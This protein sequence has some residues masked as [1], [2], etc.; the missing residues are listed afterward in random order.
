MVVIPYI[1]SESIA[2]NSII[3]CVGSGQ[4][5]RRSYSKV[6]STNPVIR[7]FHQKLGKTPDFLIHTPGD[8]RGNHTVIEVKPAKVNKSGSIRRNTGGIR[9][10]LE[11]LS[12]FKREARYQCAIYLVYGCKAADFA[13]HVKEIAEKVQEFELEPIELWLH[14]RPKEP[15]EYHTTLQRPNTSGG[16]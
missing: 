2:T 10:D 6:K 7:I 5:T 11:T 15:A 1:V 12:R 13:E 9:K 8:G 16:G 14:E 3:K 4:Q